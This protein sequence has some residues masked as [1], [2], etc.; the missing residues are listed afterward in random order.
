MRVGLIGAG[1]I[2]AWHARILAEGAHGL[3]AVCDLD[4]AR[5]RAAIA[6]SNLQFRNCY[7]RRLKVN[8][9]L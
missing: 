4:P 7:E 8:N 1:A 3:A 5:A 2:G 9:T 6:Q